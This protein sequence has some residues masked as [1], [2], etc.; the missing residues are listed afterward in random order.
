M[1]LK[2]HQPLFIKRYRGGVRMDTSQY[3]SMFLE[4][5]L[6]NLQTL[7]ESLL[8]L[9]QNPDD[10]DKVNEIFRV[11]HTIKGMAATMGFTDLAELTHKM[12]DVLAEFREGKLKVTQDVVT[13]LFDC[14]DTLEKM[15]DNVQEGS[16]EKI[17][18][19]GI[20]KALADIKEN[21][22]KSNV[23]EETQAS[24]IKSEDENKMISGDEFDLD[25]NQY[26]TSV[27]RQAREKGFNSIELKVTLS[28][29][30]LLKSARAFLIVKD[31]EDHGEI[32]KSDPSTQE[33]ENE[34]F[35]FELKFILVTK[36]TVDEILTVVNGISEV[37]KVEASLIELEGSDIAPKEAEVK[38][39]SQLP[40]I[41]KAPEEK[42][43]EAK[44][45]TK[46]PVAK[47]PTQKKEVKKAHQSVRVDLE[48][49]DN[50]MNMVSELVIYRTRLEQIVNVHKSQELNETLEQVGRTTSDLQDLVMK[51]RMLPLDTVFNR[52]PRMIRD[53]SVEL[54]K[55]INFVIEGADTELDRTVIDEI[56]EPLI[57]LLR[58]AAD[59]GIESAEKRI[60]QGKP[61]VGTVKLVAYQEGT[62]AL[63][64]VSDDG[65]GINLERVKAKAEQK[66]INTEG[67]SDSDIKNLIFAQGFSTNEVV[68]DI[69]G[70]GVGMDVVKTKIAA[71][72]G[73]VD[74]LSEEGKGST[75]VIKLPLTL[76]IIQA[77]LVKVGEETLAISL[78]FIDRVIDYKEENIKKSNG[79]EVIIYR[80]NVIPLV[81]L[82]ETL[83]IEAS[84]TDKKFVIIVNVGDKTIGL[85]VD[86]LLGQQE[87]VIKPLGKTLK[88]LD[89][90]IGATIL[91]NGLV[92][93][94]LDVGALL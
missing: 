87:I 34:E 32:L 93:L 49:I 69:S 5:S 63:I 13:V 1:D 3:M 11:A 28:E 65:A 40:V 35:D 14:L 77:L 26:D 38:E 72:G 92:T 54:N 30:T 90:Y 80:E 50:L 4:E 55:E 84:N 76:Q 79:K 10:T 2:K 74:L 45:E 86:S 68:T 83:D 18:I 75:F 9:E 27:I 59:H 41:E 37:A 29:N 31:L 19:D 48:R 39:V 52:F 23:Q 16:E 17:D 43:A 78:G 81:R 60:A 61:P 15:V 57:H 24:E 7:N 71:L 85:L 56:G 67:L 25:L 70:R 20:M 58:N 12:E 44:V 6:E 88:N 36:N 64:K 91:G 82:N 22:N 47:K 73:T 89:Q 8:D 66:G 21:G 94:I 42:P 46:Q 33:I 51:I 53:I 62:K